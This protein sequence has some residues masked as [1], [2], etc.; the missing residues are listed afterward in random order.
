MSKEKILAAAQ[1]HLQKNNLARA[2]KEYE[3][4]L[5]LDPK[6]YRSRQKLA[7]LYSR[8][9]STEEALTHYE[10]VAGYYADHAFYLKAIAVYKQ[11]QKMAPENTSYTQKL[12]KLNEQQGLTGNALAEYRILLKHYED[13]NDL[14]S[15][16]KTLE[17]MQQ[18]DRGSVSLGVKIADC[19]AKK[20][21]LNKA[22]EEFAKIEAHVRQ[23][24]DYTQLQKLY[25]H[26]MRQWPDNVAIMIGYAQAM[27]DH[28]EVLGGV[29]YLTNLLRQ[30]PDHH[31]VLSSLAAGFHQGGDYR[32]EIGCLQQLMILKEDDLDVRV[33]LFQAYLDAEDSDSCFEAISAQQGRFFSAER[34]QDLKPFLETLRE[35]LPENRDLIKMLRNVYETLGEGEKLFD[36]LSAPVEPDAAVFSAE[37][38][39]AFDSLA[40]KEP[41]VPAAAGDEFDDL[42]FDLVD[43]QTSASSTDDAFDDLA[44]DTID[45]GED[46]SFDLDGAD[47]PSSSSMVDLQADLEEIDFYLQQGLLNEAEQVCDRLMK[48]APDHD[49]VKRR[50]SLIQN[51][52]QA[53]TASPAT[54]K[55]TVELELPSLDID[56]P[57]PMS[58][59]STDQ[60]DQVTFEDLELSLGDDFDLAGPAGLADSQRGVQTVIADEDTESAYNLGIA[61][62]EMGLYDDAVAEFDKAMADPQYRISGIC[63]KAAC[64][65]EQKSFDKAEEILTLGLS[66][67]GLTQDDRIILYYESGMLYE[68]KGAYADALSSYQVV[69]DN[70]PQFRSVNMKIAELKSLLNAADGDGQRVSFA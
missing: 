23:Q 51:R 43:D 16:I 66:A 15:I 69:A 37:S 6:D 10:N 49:E 14:V 36:V 18:L 46:V 59:R 70:D 13:T 21:E 62:K 28:G 22:Q 3:K 24:G 41:S 67:K 29:E 53:Q 60:V 42:T 27:I 68:A 26:F 63:L 12:A 2:I 58:A 45:D 11:M 44:F 5:E 4:L 20:G 56:F 1:K 52:K 25:E 19:Y 8:T 54:V 61:Y 39:D 33:R 17:C 65:V 50:Q 55:Q 30:Y 35:R 32:E 38:E 9:G 31:D 64:Y 40:F 34:V 7:E 57:P 47:T 48:V